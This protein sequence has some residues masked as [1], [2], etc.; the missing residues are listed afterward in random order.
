M[1]SNL[2]MSNNDIELV[3]NNQF[4][5]KE[6][7]NY[8][9]QGAITFIKNNESIKYLVKIPVRGS[10]KNIY[11]TTDFVIPKNFNLDEINQI[12]SE[13]NKFR[14]VDQTNLENIEKELVSL[15]KEDIKFSIVLQILN[16]N[17]LMKTRSFYKKLSTKNTEDETITYQDQKSQLQETIK[18]SEFQDSLILLMGIEFDPYLISRYR[19][20]ATSL[21]QSTNYRPRPVSSYEVN[22]VKN[23]LVPAIICWLKAN[24]KYRLTNY[25][26]SKQEFKLTFNEIIKDLF[27]KC[28]EIKY[29]IYNLNLYEDDIY[30]L[31]KILYDQRFKKSN[32]KHIVNTFKEESFIEYISEYVTKNIFSDMEI[33]K[34][35]PIILKTK[36]R[37]QSIIIEEFNKKRNISNNYS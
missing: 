8:T 25:I 33:E 9:L 22:L 21:L 29:K 37:I 1:T 23:E 19:T 27:A 3:S 6:N 4:E 11:E 2:M 16:D 30:E 28:D 7:N 35:D 15:Y 5:Q 32:Y 20:L 18:S 17:Y 26:Y 10:S 31:A 14:N 36:Q 13:V 24:N 34:N 12:L